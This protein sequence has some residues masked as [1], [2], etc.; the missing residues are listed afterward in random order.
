MNATSETLLS[1]SFSRA[2]ATL[3]IR[4]F[5]RLFVR[6]FV[7]PFAVRSLARP[8]SPSPSLFA[9]C[10]FIDC[11]LTSPTTAD[12]G[13]RQFPP[14]SRS[15]FP[16]SQPHSA[17]A[18]A[19]RTTRS[20][21]RSFLLSFHAIMLSALLSCSFFRR[22]SRWLVNPLYV[23]L[24]SKLRLLSHAVLPSPSPSYLLSCRGSVV[25]LPPTLD[26][27]SLDAAEF[28]F[29]ATI[30]GLAIYTHTIHR[31]RCFLVLTSTSTSRRSLYLD[32]G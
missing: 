19:S 1:L 10:I 28:S 8:P 18:A 4:S 29:E 20:L 11:H 2:V 16:S 12:L 22:L 23:L 27:N 24:H 6:S 14:L 7:R 15:S 5:V 3:F 32:G 17:A 31:Y 26:T 21:C 9:F 25:L 13:L 30:R